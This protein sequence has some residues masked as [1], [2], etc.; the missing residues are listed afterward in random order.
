VKSLQAGPLGM[1]EPI[2]PAVLVPALAVDWHGIRLGRG[3]G[4]YDRTL[5]LVAIVRD[6]E[7][8]TSVPVQPHD[9]PVIAALTPDGV[10]CAVPLTAHEILRDSYTC[11]H[12]VGTLV[13]RVLVT[14]R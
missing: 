14:W 2:E 7:V 9:V 5:P 11:Y 6:E 8:L 10:C 4:H 12:H 13:R 1:R 3:G